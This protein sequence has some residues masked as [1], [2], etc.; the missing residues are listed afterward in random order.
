MVQIRVYL[1]IVDC[2]CVSCD[3]KIPN[4]EPQS[5]IFGYY[6]CVFAYSKPHWSFELRV[7]G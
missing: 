5:P 7:K 4:P 3:E 2:T 1:Q 6:S